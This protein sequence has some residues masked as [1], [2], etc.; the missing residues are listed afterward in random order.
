MVESGEAVT[1]SCNRQQIP[2]SAARLVHALFISDND[3]PIAVGLDLNGLAS[4]QDFLSPV[5]EFVEDAGALAIVPNATVVPPGVQTLSSITVYL[6]SAPNGA[7][8][9]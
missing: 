9:R 1:L 8:G 6:E 5:G 4:G 7:A 3:T 2:S